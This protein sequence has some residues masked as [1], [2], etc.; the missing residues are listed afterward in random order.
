[1]PET[2][3]KFGVKVRNYGAT[4]EIVMYVNVIEEKWDCS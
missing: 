3:C 1:L 2:R 4:V